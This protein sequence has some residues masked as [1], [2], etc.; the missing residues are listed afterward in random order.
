MWEIGNSFYDVLK[1]M[2]INA[3]RL[4][5]HVNACQNMYYR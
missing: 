4:T 2:K 3:T 1:N 5:A